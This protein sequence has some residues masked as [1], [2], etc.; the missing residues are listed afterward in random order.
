M[1]LATGAQRAWECEM[2]VYAVLLA[3]CINGVWALENMISEGYI[4]MVVK[5]MFGF[6]PYKT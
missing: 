3:G 4:T 2:M 6:D 1:L 5:V